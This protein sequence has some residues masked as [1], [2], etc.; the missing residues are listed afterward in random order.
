[1]IAKQLYV[2]T[3]GFFAELSLPSVQCKFGHLLASCV[4]VVGV[5]R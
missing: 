1:V 5:G 2:V 3:Q 4:G